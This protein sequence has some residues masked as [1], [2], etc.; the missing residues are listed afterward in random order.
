M[1]LKSSLWRVLRDWLFFTT[2]I[3]GVLTL[4]FAANVLWTHEGI[5]VPAFT[6]GL[7]CLSAFAWKISRG[8]S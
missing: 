7:A 3:C 6:L 1:S 4:L 2:M 5:L 8:K